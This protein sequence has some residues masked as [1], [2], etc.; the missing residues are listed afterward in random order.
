MS[1]A[2]KLIELTKDM[3]EEKIAEVIDFAEFIKNKEKKEQL[4]IMEDLLIENA[5]AMEELSK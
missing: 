4:K 2:E 3:S 1:L 5:E